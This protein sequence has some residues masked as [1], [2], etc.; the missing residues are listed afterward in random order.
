MNESNESLIPASGKLTYISNAGVLIQLKDR[1]ILIDGLC[2]SNNP[3]YKDPSAD[4]AQK[5][6]GGI[7]PF[8]HLDLMLITHEHSDHFDPISVHEFRENNPQTVILSTPSVISKLK[9]HAPLNKESHHLME[10]D[11]S[12]HEVEIRTVQGIKIHIFSLAHMG[13]SQGETR[14]YAYLIEYGLKLLHVGDA[15]PVPENYDQLNLLPEKI[16]YL[17]APFPYIGLPS[18]RRVIQDYINPRKIAVLHFPY[19]EL[20]R[21]GWI[22][23]TK[24]SFAH[25]KN[26]FM[27]TNCLE[28][29]GMSLILSF[30]S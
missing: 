16:D 17:I 24:K 15:S 3:I 14:N 10:F 29:L 20:D 21:F 28:E 19:Q 4:I 9:S 12:L 1:K 5:I 11:L 2:R 8:D 27:E 22:R 6:K 30:M 13:K 7:P 25:V 18:A 23:T 26:D